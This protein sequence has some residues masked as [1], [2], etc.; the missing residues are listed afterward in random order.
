M[1][2]DF[3][4]KAITAFPKFKKKQKIHLFLHIVDSFDAFGPTSCYSAER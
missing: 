3:V 1:C 2:F 4:T